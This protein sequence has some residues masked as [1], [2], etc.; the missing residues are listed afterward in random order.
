MA[1]SSNSVACSAAY[2]G[3]ALIFLSVMGE[4]SNSAA[5]RKTLFA[6][7]ALRLSISE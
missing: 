3:G 5:L 6:L 7:V 1:G 2:S 4:F